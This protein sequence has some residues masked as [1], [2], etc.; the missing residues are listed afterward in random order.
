MI[1][2]GTWIE[3]EETVLE[4]SDRAANIPEETRK[5]PLKVWIRGFCENDC[6]ISQMVEVKTLTGR[7][8]KG[9]VM[10]EEPGY[11]HSFGNY[12]KEIS[13][14]GLQARQILNS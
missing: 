6:E 10:S 11:Y 8:L 4:S 2:K 9:R 5:T 1:K 7:I 13:Y 12:V 3:V 14:I